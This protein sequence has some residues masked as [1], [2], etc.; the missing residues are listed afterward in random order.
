M[1]VVL[2]VPNE[3][4]APE[5]LSAL[6]LCLF[7]EEIPTS[8]EQ[9]SGLSEA[10][11]NWSYWLLCT[12][13]HQQ[14]QIAGQVKELGTRPPERPRKRPRPR[15]GSKEPDFRTHLQI[16]TLTQPC[17]RLRSAKSLLLSCVPLNFFFFE[18]EERMQG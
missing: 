7:L 8:A 6:L 2:C 14:L 3:R 12:D 11:G 15:L 1:V 4:D 10:D 17:W 18:A 5:R 16:K 13:L 9:G